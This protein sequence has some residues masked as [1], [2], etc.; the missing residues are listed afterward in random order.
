[1][2]RAKGNKKGR[3][4]IAQARVVEGIHTGRSSREGS[5]DS[6]DSEQGDPDLD[7][8]T[9][10]RRGRKRSQGPEQGAQTE[11]FKGKTNRKRGGQGADAGLGNPSD[12]SK[13][14]TKRRRGSS[15]VRQ[16]GSAADKRSNGQEAEADT[17]QGI[18][19]AAQRANSRKKSKQGLSTNRQVDAGDLANS[20]P[21]ESE[22]NE[23]KALAACKGSHEANSLSK[24]TARKGTNNNQLHPPQNR[25]A[26]RQ[27]APATSAVD[28]VS[29]GHQEGFA[30]GTRAG[31]TKAAK[32]AEE[33]TIGDHENAVST[34]TKGKT[35][36]KLGIGHL[37]TGA[38]GAKVPRMRTPVQEKVPLKS[39]APTSR[40]ALTPTQ[41]T[42]TAASIGAA[43][44][45]RKRHRSSQATPNV[46][47]A[48]PGSSPGGMLQL[49][50]P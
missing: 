14:K 3:G 19:E 16:G 12:S 41:D 31:V 42:Q 33:G 36:A 45:Q 38:L 24:R 49:C 11:N 9:G 4:E 46:A 18:E 32:S 47:S 1:M 6:R 22:L 15:G 5:R 50:R 48:S 26:S 23:S 43:L 8:V 2:Q 28:A 10:T 40:G 39:T 20:V 7:A 35:R 25:V 30:L 29:D 37:K 27:K 44:L 21:M 17:G 13:A 34:A